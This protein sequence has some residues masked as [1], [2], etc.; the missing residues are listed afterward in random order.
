MKKFYVMMILGYLFSLHSGQSQTQPGDSSMALPQLE[1]PEITIVGKKAIT[2]PF[3]R[4]GEIYDVNIYQAAPPDSS[5]LGERLA[6]ALP[7]G[8]MPRD[9]EK[10]VPIHAAVQGAF[11]SFSSGTLRAFLDYERGRWNF[12][13]NT[14]YASTEGHVDNSKATLFDIDLNAKTLISTDNDVLKTLRF[15]GGMSFST[16][17]Y[18]MS[19]YSD[20]QRSRSNFSINTSLSS[21]DR[22][23]IA[24]DLG[25]ETKFSG[26]TDS[27]P[28]NELKVTSVSP[29]LTS[30]VALNIGKLRWTTDV[31]FHSISLDYSTPTQSVTLFDVT[32]SMHW[33]VA[34][35]WS[36]TL[37]FVFNDGSDY[38]GTT[39]TIALPTAS[40]EWKSG[41]DKQFT[42]WWKPKMQMNTYDDW[43][44]Y[45]PYLFRE[46]PIQ[47]ERIPINLGV[48]FAMST[49]LL[50][51]SANVSYA[52]YSNKSVIVGTPQIAE[53][54]SSTSINSLQA[55]LLTYAEANQT[56]FEINATYKPVEKFN[57]NFSGC[58]QP[59][60][61]TGESDQLPMTPLF[62]V[63]SK[64]AYEL[65]KPITLWAGIETW[66]NRNVVYPAIA[67]S[68]SNSVSTT[69]D[70]VALLNIGASTTIVPRTELSASV[71]N[72]LDLTYDWWANYPAPGL[73]FSIQAKVNL[74]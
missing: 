4:K 10:R 74:K 27:D 70:G 33:K 36:A 49:Q 22:R 50:D 28:N 15:L 37:G 56:K 25:L 13:G 54:A 63:N 52:E 64:I 17:K 6:T 57:I 40:L 8:S 51:V 32:S 42:F 71:R 20:L 39:R 9:E 24:I 67:S 19:A 72:L 23:G 41:N 3:A 7:N 21:L 38:A 12:S 43:I 55:L 47:P 35:A 62:M 45:N 68:F 46:L 26:V 31:A 14:G 18:G 11:G 16:E 61:A 5:L 34:D 48:S 59:T 65:P 69:I 44:A 2:L 66:G 53:P 58:I 1:I 73:Q 60:F 30:A 29:N